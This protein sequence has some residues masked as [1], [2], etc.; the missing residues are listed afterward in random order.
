MAIS[1]C[2]TCGETGRFESV[3]YAPL[4]VE[5][6]QCAKCGAV[7]GVTDQALADKLEKL[8]KQLADRSRR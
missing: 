2:P 1:K 5:L 3:H 7:V 8:S 6:I 4:V